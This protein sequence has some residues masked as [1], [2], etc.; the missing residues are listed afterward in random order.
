MRT[1]RL[2]PTNWR[3]KDSYATARRC[4]GRPGTALTWP[5]LA[6]AVRGGYSKPVN[7]AWLRSQEVQQ[8]D[9]RYLLNHPAY[10]PGLYHY[11]LA[12]DLK[13]LGEDEHLLL[14]VP[15]VDWRGVR[16]HLLRVRADVTDLFPSRAYRTLSG[17]ARLP[18]QRLFHVLNEQPRRDDRDFFTIDAAAW[19]L[20]THRTGNMEVL[21]EWE[22]L[23]ERLEA[24]N[25][26]NTYGGF[27]FIPAG[28][29]ITYGLTHWI[30][31]VRRDV[32]GL[33]SERTLEHLSPER[34]A[35]HYIRTGFA[36][37]LKA[38]GRKEHTL[39][40]EAFL[41]SERENWVSKQTASGREAP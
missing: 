15:R 10:G 7:W 24:R 33:L 13:F 6:A 16:K 39:H 26:N 23:K 34:L 38:W 29:F 20:H 1:T 28:N 5:L 12:H 17:R 27:A 8:G 18:L 40:D 11:W 25:R 35:D 3:R 30:P 41:L 4:L 36:G 31:A 21:K 9:A 2:D 37:L 22:V 32:E 19:C 14:D